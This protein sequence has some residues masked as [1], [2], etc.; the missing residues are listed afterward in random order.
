MAFLDDRKNKM[1]QDEREKVRREAREAAQAA[2]VGVG[3]GAGQLVGS[4]PERNPI[5]MPSGPGHTL[6]ASAVDEDLE[7]DQPPAYNG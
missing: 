3:A 2:G 6:S 4:S 1:M 7:L 5:P